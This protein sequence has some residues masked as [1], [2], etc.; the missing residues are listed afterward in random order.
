MLHKTY[1]TLYKACNNIILVCV[2]V[3]A[4]AMEWAKQD[5]K[6]TMKMGLQTM[7]SKGEPSTVFMATSLSELDILTKFLK[8]HRHL[9]GLF[10]L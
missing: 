1:Y 3:P 10:F 5:T 7:A 2:C 9:V 8:Q 4:S 6:Q